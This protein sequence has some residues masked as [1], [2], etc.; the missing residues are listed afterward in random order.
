MAFSTVPDVQTAK[1][2]LHDIA[3]FSSEVGLMS[4]T[5]NVNAQY[6]KQC[7]NEQARGCDGAS[8][9]QSPQE[10]EQCEDTSVNHSIACNVRSDTGWHLKDPPSCK[11]PANIPRV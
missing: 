6:L 9:L 10:A 3:Q 8:G 5:L 4:E 1:R 11:T 2:E 7:T